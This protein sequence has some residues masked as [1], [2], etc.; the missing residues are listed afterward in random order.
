MQN[1]SSATELYRR[2]SALSNSKAEAQRLE[3][4]LF[5][6][7]VEAEEAILGGKKIGDRALESRERHRRALLK[8][9]ADGL[10]WKYFASRD[11]LAVKIFAIHPA[12]GFMYGKK[13]VRAEREALEDLKRLDEID[14]VIQNDITN[15]LRSGDLTYCAGPIVEQIEIKSGGAKSFATDRAK[16]QTDRREAIVDYRLTGVTEHD[17][18]MPNA[19]KEDVLR[20]ATS[21][22]SR[23]GLATSPQPSLGPRS[24]FSVPGERSY[25][26]QGI[27]DVLGEA[28]A[29]GRSWQVVENGVI[30][31]GWN[32]MDAREAFG[33]SM[34][35]IIDRS[36]W[37]APNVMIGQL[38]EQ[39][40]PIENE[41]LRYT[42]PIT[43]FEVEAGAVAG[44]I[45]GS[46]D[47]CVIVDT[48]VVAKLFAER[49]YKA[50]C[51]GG[52]WTVSSNGDWRMEL[53]LNP[54]NEVLYAL[55]TL[56]S[57]VNACV[58]AL[59]AGTVANFHER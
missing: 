52:R 49:G 20:R 18:L 24:H 42:T 9:I 38:S 41:I 3:E 31:I 21:P 35:E 10:S 15:I 8:R 48:N 28:K 57:F 29:R 39:F 5:L 12:P 33:L 32:G 59:E 17:S 2:L 53:G 51:D 16:R 23:L 37:I 43:A 44:L 27:G 47:C 14:F 40:K 13:G 19:V 55:E 7:I 56:P 50:E 6:H 45:E 1:R 25:H 30:L 54:W 4:D 46:S 22:Q 58:K 36:G 26:W 11:R 34:S